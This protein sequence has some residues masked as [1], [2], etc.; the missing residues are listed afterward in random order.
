M[1]APPN[2]G[3]E[4]V[5]RLRDVPGFAAFNG[6]AGVQ[7]G[8][9]PDGIPAR[10][11]PVAFELGVIAGTSTFNPILSQFLPNPDDGKVSLARARV[12]GMRD[13][14]AV[15]RSHPFI[16]RAPEV[17]RQALAFVAH[18]RFERALAAEG[19]PGVAH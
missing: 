2:G 9:G 19:A 8:T 10:L 18:G 4:L 1:L 7:L 6:P 3:S 14:L 5:D 15:E 17:I 12:T 11:G 13:F 16:M